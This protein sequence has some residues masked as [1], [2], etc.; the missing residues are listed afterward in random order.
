MRKSLE[1]RN[2]FCDYDLRTKIIDQLNESNF[3]SNVNKDQIRSIY[4]DK[5]PNYVISEK[6]VW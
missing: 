6:K 2:P 4:K 5:L 1:I 3:K